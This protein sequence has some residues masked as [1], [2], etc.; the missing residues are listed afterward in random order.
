[1]HGKNDS[2]KAQPIVLELKLA[3]RRGKEL[4]DGSPYPNGKWAS[5]E[6]LRGP[7]AGNPEQSRGSVGKISSGRAGCARLKGGNAND[8]SSVRYA[9][10]LVQVASPRGGCIV[11]YLLFLRRC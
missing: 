5:E 1:M 2:L 9:V 11:R 6:P 8:D 7:I 10:S 4:A 3:R